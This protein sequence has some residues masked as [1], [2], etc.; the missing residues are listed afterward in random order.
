V[1]PF[2]DIRCFQLGGGRS[3]REGVRG[4]GA[5]AA[6]AGAAGAAAAGR[7][8][9]GRDRGGVVQLLAAKIK[10]GSCRRSCL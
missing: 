7:G 5:A 1:P 8:R 10:L 9:G 6:G 3:R 2:D 4:E